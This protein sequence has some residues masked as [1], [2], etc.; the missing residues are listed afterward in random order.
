M[1]LSFIRWLFMLISGVVGYYIGSLVELQDPFRLLGYYPPVGA[2]IGC[3][4]GL[5]L[6]IAEQKLQRVSVRGLSSLVFGLILGVLMAKLI[7]NIL[8]LLPLGGFILSIAEIILTLVF[9]YLGAVMALRGKDEFNIIIP[10]VRFKRQDVYDEVILLDT[11]IIIDGRIADIYK[12]NFLQGR[13]IV[14]RCVLAE[15]QALA[16]SADDI[17]R[18]RGRRGLE[19]LKIIQND[20]QVDIHI[21]EDDL[22]GP[23]S[24]DH[25]LVKL[26]RQMDAGIC[27]LDFN[28]GKMAALRGIKILNINE[29]IAG[30]KSVLL[31]GDLKEI[32][33]IKVGKE[34]GQAVAYLEDGTMVVVSDA[35][36][37][38]GQK[39]NVQIVS[40]LQTQAGKMF[41]ASKR[42]THLLFR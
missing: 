12:T 17:K 10:Y 20:P 42:H 19:M 5:L 8:S 22:T 34:P 38:I 31:P 3:S 18:E 36:A 13:L 1:T 4:S 15:L 26:A 37:F 39:R 41:F 24:V 16:D 35:A 7:S 30:L 14:P 28:L 32:S 27:T 2:A 6:I 9:S 40:V 25:K 11:N 21:H 33:L 23:D 29:L